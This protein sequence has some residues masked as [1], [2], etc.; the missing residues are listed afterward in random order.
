MAAGNLPEAR[1]DS[2][3]ILATINGS[4]T[5]VVWGGRNRKNRLLPDVWKGTLGDASAPEVVWERVPDKQDLDDVQDLAEEDGG[6]S[7]EESRGSWPFGRK[8]HKKPKKKEKKKRKRSQHPPPRKGH[9]AVYAERHNSTFMVRTLLG[10]PLQNKLLCEALA[11]LP[12]S[13]YFI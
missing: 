2:A 13:V 4:S 10:S 1:R 7:E 3:G 8:K 6:E 11:I 12:R 9:S 5:I